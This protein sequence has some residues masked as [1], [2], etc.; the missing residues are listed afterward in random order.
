M[1]DMKYI[2]LI[3]NL[4]RDL[5]SRFEKLT[6]F[7]ENEKLLLFIRHILCKYPE[8]LRKINL[9]EI[10]LGEIIEVIEDYLENLRKKKNLDTQFLYNLAIGTFKEKDEF[11]T[12]ILLIMIG[13]S[14]SNLINQDLNIR[15]IRKVYFVDFKDND[16][17]FS[18]EKLNMVISPLKTMSNWKPAITNKNLKK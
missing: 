7:L 14:F 3:K 1:Y 4:E 6:L 17:D 15:K 10:T 5:S 9:N 13:F 11:S 16:F 12:F 8:I 18:K 2:F